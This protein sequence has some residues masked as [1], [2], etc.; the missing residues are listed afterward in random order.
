MG[1]AGAYFEPVAIFWL[2]AVLT[3]PTL[4]LASLGG[5][6]RAKADAANRGAIVEA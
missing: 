3:L 4:L 1:L 2:T 5:Q 6:G